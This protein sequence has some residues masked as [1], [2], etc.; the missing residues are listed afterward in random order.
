MAVTVRGLPQAE[1]TCTTW[2]WTGSAEDVITLA[3]GAAALATA[4][5]ALDTGLGDTTTR[6]AFATTGVGVTVR[7]SW[8]G[9]AI[10]ALT[11]GDAF[12]AAASDAAA[13][14]SGDV[15][16]AASDAAAIS[17]GEA[18]AGGDSTAI[19]LVDA[20]AGTGDTT[21]VAVVRPEREGVGAGWAVDGRTV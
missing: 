3:T 10:E 11:D 16:V 1:R 8:E 19:R 9:A 4:A 2:R 6:L 17:T 18:A 14:S 15:S 21:G 20:A 5:A 12:A 13:R 7:V